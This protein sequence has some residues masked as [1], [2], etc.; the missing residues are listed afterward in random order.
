AGD[1]GVGVRG[2]DQPAGG[3]H[4]GMRLA[5]AHVVIEQAVVKCRRRVQ[6][7]GRG[8]QRLL[9]A[10]AASTAQLLAR[11]DEILLSREWRNP[12]EHASILEGSASDWPQEGGE[13]RMSKR[14]QTQGT[15]SLRSLSRFG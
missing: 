12:P 14:T 7:R 5:A 6:R 1:Y 13:E 11:H 4:A 3:K 8:I 2:R 15:L 9:E 10:R